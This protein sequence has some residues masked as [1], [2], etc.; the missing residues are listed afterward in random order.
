M[1]NKIANILMLSFL[2]LVSCNEEY[3]D[4]NAP[5][6]DLHDTSWIIGFNPLTPKED[7]L[8]INI[9]S[10]ISFVDLSQGLTDHRWVIE[11][12]N[13]FLRER[14]TASDS[15]PLFIK[16]NDTISKDAKIH[17]FFRKPGLNKV[18]LFN[19]YTSPISHKTSIGTLESKKVGDLY[20]IDTTFT[21]DVFD[22]IK[23][24]F[25]ILQ[26][27][28]EKCV[29]TADSIPSLSNKENWP[30]VEVEAG[31][32]LTFEDLSE[33]GRPNSRKWTV[34]NGSPATAN[35]ET[36]TIKFFKLGT[37]E[38]GNIL[39]NRTNIGRTYP[40][41]STEKIIPL[42]V[43]VIKSSQP[44]TIN[45]QIKETKEEILRFQVTGELVPFTAQES[46]FTVHV[47]NG[48]FDQN[49]AVKNAKVSESDAT[50]IE[51]TL[52]DPIYNSDEI[53]VSYAGGTIASSDER[54]LED[55]VSP[56]TVTPYFGNNILSFNS[57]FEDSDSAANKAF[58]STYWVGDG[59]SYGSG[60]YYERTTDK[61]A[62]GSASMKFES[63]DANPFPTPFISSS[64]FAA[65]DGI[66]AGTY[67][68][69]LKLF[70]ESGSDIKA[71]RTI[72]NKPTWVQKDWDLESLERG[73]WVELKQE[74]VFTG[75]VPTDATFQLRILSALNPGVTGAQKLY[76]DDISL[77]VIE[78]R[79]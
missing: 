5:D 32:A 65:P 70:I 63:T 39:V 9:D 57:G 49:I 59:N 66:A 53:T 33:I 17:V 67:S 56:V 43:K 31:G 30:I 25:R 69:S 44:F 74:V 54:S 41:A 72:I 3:L 58:A 36:A 6:N 22:H 68:M 60:Y 10:Y 77:I 37:F 19:T 45:G 51:L 24:S 29:V 15:L 16:N 26:G 79:P 55:F 23:P 8:L 14:F 2:L 1:K 50:Y 20:V 47:K 75:D 78:L 18:R 52:N 71:F 64:A 61:F 7:Q 40:N 35:G 27:T 21:F 76:I 62:S 34:P 13:N 48:T 12:G 11:K 4:Y 38:A 28:T 73:K 46:F 42:L